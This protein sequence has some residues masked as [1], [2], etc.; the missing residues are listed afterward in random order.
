[1]DRLFEDFFGPASGGNVGQRQVVPTYLLPLDV[2][3]LED[4]FQ[5]QAPVPGFTPDEVDVTFA[6]GML[7]IQAEHSA[8]SSQEQ[9]GWLRREVGYGNYQRT[10]Q[11]PG[12]VKEDDI[13]AEFEN[14]VLTVTVPKVPRPQP[15][16]IQIAG[17]LQKAVSGKV[18]K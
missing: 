6:E 2:R 5:I 8:E 3:Q 9:G 4:G 12:D 17:G 7:T 18:S 1:M 16:K 10:I 15:K 13:S 11:L 14:G